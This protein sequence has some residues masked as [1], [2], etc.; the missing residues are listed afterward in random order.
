MPLVC[1]H[2]LVTWSGCYY[3]DVIYQDGEE[4]QPDAC[5]VCRCNQGDVECTTKTCPPTTCD[6]PIQ[7]PGLCCPVCDAGVYK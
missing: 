2:S 5:A 6:N 3:G 7:P 4:F 1:T